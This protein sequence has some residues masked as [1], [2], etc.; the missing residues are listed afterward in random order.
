MIK[1]KI[2]IFCS[3]AII[4][5]LLCISIKVKNRDGNRR[6]DD[7]IE[8]IRWKTPYV[9]IENEKKNVDTSIMQ[10]SKGR[11]WI[12]WSQYGQGWDY[13]IM[14]S[15][16][17]DGWNWSEPFQIT[18]DRGNRFSPIVIQDE[19]GCY[20]LFYS[21]R[22]INIVYS[23]N[24]EE[25][26][27]TSI[28]RPFYPDSFKII[29]DDNNTNLMAF[30]YVPYIG[31][32]SDP[33]QSEVYIAKSIDA[34][35]WTEPQFIDYGGVSSLFQD[36]DQNYWL[37]VDNRYFLDIYRSPMGDNWDRVSRLSLESYYGGSMI[38]DNDNIYRLAWLSVKGNNNSTI[39]L[40][41]SKDGE[42]WEYSQEIYTSNKRVSN[43]TL[44]Q[45]INGKYWLIWSSEDKIWACQSY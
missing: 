20:R 19:E 18:N 25:W 2:L 28:V 38:E 1:T 36:S 31:E 7:F 29:S 41:S 6:N 27:N 34:T 16:S 23:Q 10:D 9:I 35:N 43:P 11:Y 4:I 37:I 13:Q 26:T 17:D 30:S 15:H 22:G 24:G 32:T 5:V 12:S 14:I 39:M 3:V 21:D 45:D 8:N 40:T 42:N 44:F 33:P